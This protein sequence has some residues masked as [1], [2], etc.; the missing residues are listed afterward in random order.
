VEFALT[1]LFVAGLGFDLV[2][3]WLLARGLIAKPEI[4]VLRNTSYWG[5][6]APSGLAAAEDRIDG[7]FGVASLLV[8][9]ALQALGYLLDLARSDTSEHTTGRTLTALGLLIV[10]VALAWVTWR[11]TH[12]WLVRRLLIEMAHWQPTRS[13]EPP[14][15]QDRANPT[16]LVGWGANMGELRREGE[17]DWAYAKRAF[18]LTDDDLIEP[19]SLVP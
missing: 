9:F 16:N 1:D 7:Q 5:S 2:G 6:D 3:A 19:A 8:G 14:T 4:I 11:L 15:R 10:A 18:G 17:D 12:R 13:D